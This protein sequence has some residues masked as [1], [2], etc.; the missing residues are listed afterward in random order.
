MAVT[1]GFFEYKEVSCRINGL[2]FLSLDN[3]KLRISNL[4]EKIKFLHIGTRIYEI[5]PNE[6]ITIELEKIVQYYH[7]FVFD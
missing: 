6:A 1:V 5:N 4:T 2:N 3:S 7:I